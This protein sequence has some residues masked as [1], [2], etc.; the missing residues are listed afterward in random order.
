MEVLLW[1]LHRE[2]IV[3]IQMTF[4]GYDFDV[5]TGASAL[6]VAWLVRRRAPEVPALKSNRDVAGS[7]G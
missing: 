1:A 2:D 6:V 4:E 7:P 3:P 5:L